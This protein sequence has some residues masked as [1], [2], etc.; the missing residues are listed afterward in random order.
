MCDAPT[1]AIQ[2][3]RLQILSRPEYNS[4][5]RQRLQMIYQ[6]VKSPAPPMQRG[7]NVE[8]YLPNARHHKHASAGCLKQD[9]AWTH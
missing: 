5:L 9:F 8:I 1:S 6:Y 2:F 3:Y 4:P 7:R